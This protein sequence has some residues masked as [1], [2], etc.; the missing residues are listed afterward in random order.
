MRKL[1]FVLFISLHI[2]I[3]FDV[4]DVL[5]KTRMTSCKLDQC[6]SWL[7]KPSWRRPRTLW[8][9]VVDTSLLEGRV[10][11]IPKSMIVWSLLKKSLLEH[12]S[13]ASYCPFSNLPVFGEG[14]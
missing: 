10:P 2:A 6:L 12:D 4:E 11:D 9:E 3:T 14:H 7:V 13:P 1:N 5:L 8:M